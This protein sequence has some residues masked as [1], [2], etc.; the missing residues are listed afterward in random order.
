MKNFELVASIFDL[1][2][3]FLIFITLAFGNDVSFVKKINQYIL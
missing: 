2:C 1:E 3:V